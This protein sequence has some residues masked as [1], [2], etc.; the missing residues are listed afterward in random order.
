MQHYDAILKLAPGDVPLVGYR[1]WGN[2]FSDRKARFID[3]ASVYTSVVLS[4]K[5]TPEATFIQTK[6]SVYKLA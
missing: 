6:N 2:I 4:I 1:L 5:A 3:G